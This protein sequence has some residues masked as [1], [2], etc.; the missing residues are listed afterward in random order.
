MF[1]CSCHVSKRVCIQLAD[2]SNFDL[3]AVW[4]VM[5]VI[6]ANLPYIPAGKQL[7][8]EVIRCVSVILAAALMIPYL[9]TNRGPR[10]LVEQMASM[11]FER[12]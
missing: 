6:V 7:Q 4:P 11:S 8:E 1:E 12:S 3:L 10:F 9:A 2:V 5:D